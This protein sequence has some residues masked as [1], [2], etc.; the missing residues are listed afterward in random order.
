MTMFN[1][2]MARQIDFGDDGDT[3]GDTGGDD[4]TD[5]GYRRDL[6]A[7]VD[8]LQAQLPISVADARYYLNHWAAQFKAQNGRF[9]TAGDADDSLYVGA[10]GLV[11]DL[12]DAFMYNGVLYGGG[13][14]GFPVPRTWPGAQGSN[15]PTGVPVLT[16]DVISSLL[17]G[18]Q[19]SGGGGGGGAREPV[20]DLGM[21]GE[22]ATDAWRYYL[23][24]EPPDSAALAKKYAAEYA[25]F[26]KQGG[27]LDF[28]TWIMGQIRQTN[29]YKTLY[30]RKPDFMGESEWVDTYRGIAAKYGTDWTT[31]D[32][33]VRTGMKSGASPTGF[34]ER[35]ENSREVMVNSSTFGNKIA[36]LVNQ[37]GVLNR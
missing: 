27:N 19:P 37:L 33:N 18:V 16:G 35:I 17:R 15:Q 36:N 14:F 11:A 8:L 29:R 25:A 4:F 26:A 5:V 23:L 1:R 31:M 6:N 3:G 10:L 22:K 7:L 12:P 21:V 24:D 32:K 34:G 2:V 28:T 9:P 20:F 13:E 30:F